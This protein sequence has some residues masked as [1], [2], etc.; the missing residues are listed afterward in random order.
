MAFK[1]TLCL[2]VLILCGMANIGHAS[3][4]L[5][6]YL[7]DLE[8]T[9]SK[10]QLNAVTE[11][12]KNP[13]ELSSFYANGNQDKVIKAISR[14]VK[15]SQ[16]DVIALSSMLFFQVTGKLSKSDIHSVE[17]NTFSVEYK[18]LHDGFINNTSSQDNKVRENSLI[19]LSVLARRI[20]N[21]TV[22]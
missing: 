11:L 6:Q 18:T 10:T 4:E 14:A 5:D 2:S 15:S 1:T 3:A 8:S 9:D 19:A 17:R 22:V 13:S 20:I 12:L 7:T 21:K 16:A